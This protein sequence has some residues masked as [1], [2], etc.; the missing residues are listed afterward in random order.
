MID[1]FTAV[2]YSLTSQHLQGEQ[3]EDW[4][5]FNWILTEGRGREDFFVKS[6]GAL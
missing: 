6:L 4:I 2:L 3:M 5:G 1:C